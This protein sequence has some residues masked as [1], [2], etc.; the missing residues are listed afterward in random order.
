MSVQNGVLKNEQLARTFGWEKVLGAMAAFSAEVLPN[1]PVRFTVNDGFYLGELPGG[2]SERVHAL[3]HTLENAGIVAQVTS[4]I[5]ALEWSKYVLF[6]CLMVPAVLTRLET[7]KFLQD[8]LMA[9][10]TASLID[11]MATIAA[12]HQIELD[13][14][15][16]LAVKTLSQLSLDDKIAQIAQRGTQFAAQAPTHKVSTLQDLEQGKRRLEVEE[17]LGYAVQQGAA[18][19]VPTPTMDTCYRLIAGINRSLQ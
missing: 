13:D 2:L 19:G 7:Y 8:P 17:T 10:I 16:F 1:G 18:L 4:S 3:G 11:E 6:V 9:S 5:Q 12:A 14:T 15:A